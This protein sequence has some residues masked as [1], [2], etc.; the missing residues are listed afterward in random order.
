MNGIAYFLQTRTWSDSAARTDCRRT[1]YGSRHIGVREFRSGEIGPRQIRV[2]HLRSHDARTG[3]IRVR[4]I[5]VNQ[6]RTRP[7]GSG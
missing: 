5:G 3:E 6:I 7:I 4:Q 1:S 2:R